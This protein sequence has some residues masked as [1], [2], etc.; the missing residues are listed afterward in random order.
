MST[1]ATIESKGCQGTGITPELAKSLHDNLGKTIVAV[2]EITADKR[3]ENRKGD[4][5]V[6]LIINTIEVA[7]NHDTAEHIRELSH[8]FNYERKL[9]ENGPTLPGTDDEPAPKVAD[10]L[11]AGEALKPHEFVATEEDGKTICDRCGSEEDDARHQA[12][13]ITAAADETG[14]DAG[15]S[16]ESPEPDEE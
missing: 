4:E 16:D 2:V 10:I 14:D 1:T 15:S 9:I 13:V 12:D 5:K 11:A 3:S 8:A 7:P 6:G